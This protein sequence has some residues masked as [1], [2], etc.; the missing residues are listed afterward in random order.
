MAGRLFFFEGPDGVGKSTIVSALKERLVYDGSK[1]DFLNFPGNLQGTLGKVV[2]EI[3]HEPERYG[4]SRM[5]ELAKQTLHIAAHID[6]I[7]TIIRPRLG[8]GINVV[9]D[10]FWW[11]TIVYG[12]AGGVEPSVLS[13]L[14][15]TE[16]L[17]WGDTKPSIAFLV[18]RDQPIDRS[19][20]LGPWLKLR[21]RYAD[22]CIEQRENH[23]VVVLENS[24]S[25]D[26]VVG[27][28]LSHIESA[29]SDA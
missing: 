15:A 10:R 9:L 24:A 2:Y 26:N 18:D 3:H 12:E 25:I 11:S 17:V 5:S 1:F 8:A 7:E 13:Q 28:A 29:V 21:S 14:A 16:K 20:H 23:E 4:I 19:D 22:L 6:A 27:H